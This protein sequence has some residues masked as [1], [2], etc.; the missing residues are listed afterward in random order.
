M[1]ALKLGEE[2]DLD[3]RAYELRRAGR[4]VRL[5]R[6]PMQILLLLI[7]R[8]PDLVTREQIV[9]RVWGQ[10]VFFETDNSI[11]VAI[12][13]LR[14][15]LKD[16]PENPRFI[17]TVTGMGYRFIAPLAEDGSAQPAPAAQ[18]SS[19]VDVAS[20]VAL[21][22]APSRRRWI[23]PAAL[24]LAGLAGAFHIWSKFPSATERPK[25]RV[26]L[27]VLPFEN[28][29]GDV[30]QDYFS[31]G[32]T[33]EMI[34]RLGAIDPQQLGIIARTS[35]MYYKHVPT[36]LDKLGSELGVQYVL[37]GSV[38]RESDRVRIT[39]QLIYLKDQTHLWARNYDREQ[40]DVLRV[41][42]EIAMEIADQ[43][44]ALLNGPGPPAHPASLSPQ[45][46]EAYD[47][48]LRGRYDWNQRTPDGFQRAVESFQQAL[49]RNPGEA[50]A[51]AGL[52]DTYTLM[53]T[54]GYAPQE[55][56]IPK[57]RAAA[58]RALELDGSLAAAHTSLALIN[59][60]YDW[61]WQT[62]EDRFRKAIA[63]D[64]NYA[65]AHHW[66]AEYLAFQGRF[67][68]ALAESE[69]ARQ[70]D[71]RSLIIAADNGVIL[72]LARRYDQAIA[73]FQGVLALEPNFGRAH[74]I[75]YVY[76]QRGQFAEAQE[77]VKKWLEKG[78]SPWL[79]AL[80]AYV[81]GRSGNVD[82]ARRAFSHMEESNRRWKLGPFQLR[83]TAYLG[84]GLNDE[85]LAVLEQ[86]CENH[87][88]FLVSLRVDPI[89]DP[90][91]KD[92]RF[93]ELLHCV[94]LAP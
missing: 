37:E 11:N 70:L 78:G 68:E 52:S 14:L 19:I 50:R 39:A 55:E 73:Q 80:T 63:L 33:E 65:T 12:R 72:Y 41:Q 93:H 34:M 58:L 35:V 45:D 48:Y 25:G 83:A 44:E 92:P 53:G 24:A 76:A 74:M 15:A 29:T 6:I 27:A 67:D 9:E 86:A 51:Y 4:A 16:D 13:K 77:Q 94:H 69:R 64:A 60:F 28:L 75:I 18:P 22:D 88:S 87:S 91:R 59:E 49:A 54:W 7:E 90:L 10:S 46:Y 3:P 23:L 89:Y 81:Q 82:E 79:D 30:G 66:Y 2:L 17:R 57:A 26:M 84:M 21:P 40:K 56:V 32:F 38:R 5:E 20:P 62:A 71:P 47:Y 61:D 43:I 8:R 31:D 42:D 36:P 1:S 85:A